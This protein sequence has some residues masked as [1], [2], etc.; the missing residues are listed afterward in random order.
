VA[1]LTITFPNIFDF[2]TLSAEK[3]RAKANELSQQAL[4]DKTIQDLTGQVQT[5]LS[6]LRSAQLVARQ[7]PIELAA[8]RA[9]ETQSRARYDASLAT[10]VEVSDAEG[11]L[12]QAES[13]DAVARLNLWH[14]LFAVAY[15][16]GNLQP[17]LDMLRGPN[18]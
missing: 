12:S 16:Q 11:L 13:D 15:A 17:F 10:L 1:G 4:Y 5:A 8:A 18:P 6:Q 9:S 14:S 2:K 7:T 3:Q